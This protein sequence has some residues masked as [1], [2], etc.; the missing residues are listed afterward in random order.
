MPRAANC[1][2]PRWGRCTG[3]RGEYSASV[4][5]DLGVDNVAVL[6]CPSL[7]TNLSAPLR[8]RRRPFAA[9][10]KVAVTGATDVV[11]GSFDPEAKAEVERTLFRLAD[12][13]GSRTCSRASCPRFC[14]SSSPAPRGRRPP[15]RRRPGLSC[16]IWCAPVPDAP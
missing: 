10:E 6:G 3:V 4:L 1:S 11:G 8:V 9:L 12:A 13:S 2:T 14:S 16:R 15:R 5:H 7:Y